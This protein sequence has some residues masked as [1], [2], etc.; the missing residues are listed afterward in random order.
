MNMAI[1]SLDRQQGQEIDLGADGLR[2]DA[3]MPAEIHKLIA[4]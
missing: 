4:S 3:E 1:M 2:R